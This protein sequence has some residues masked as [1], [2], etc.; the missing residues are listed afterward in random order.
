MKRFL[1]AATALGGAVLTVPA[2]AHAQLATF[3]ASNFA[4]QLQHYIQMLK[5]YAQQGQAYERQGQQLQEEIQTLATEEQTLQALVQSPN[6]GSAMGL[7]N[8]AGVRNPLP[9]NPYAVQG[10][11][12]GQGGISGAMGNLS[13]MANSS[14]ASNTYYSSGD[15]SWVSAEERA[16]ATGNAGA[17]GSGMAILQQIADHIPILQSLRDKL[18]TA[19]TPKE[20]QDAQ[21][22]LQTEQAWTTD[23]SSQLQAVSVI[24]AAQRDANEARQNERMTQAIDQSLAAAKANGSWP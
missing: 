15:G 17:Q 18:A 22:A 16:R 8:M 7:M 13:A 21:A 10:L 3:D 23:M 9:V 11:I 12:N 1:L 14:Y 20:V 19:T 4:Q 6:L 5:D 24:A 2:P